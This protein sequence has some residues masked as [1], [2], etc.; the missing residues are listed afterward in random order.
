MWSSEVF[1]R[2][3][4]PRFPPKESAG[5]HDRLVQEIFDAAAEDTL[6]LWAE[7]C[8]P[9]KN[10]WRRSMREPLKR[11]LKPDSIT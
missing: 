1:R 10:S 5:L 2:R 4:R 11:P 7:Q 6:A 8:L 3:D 9:L